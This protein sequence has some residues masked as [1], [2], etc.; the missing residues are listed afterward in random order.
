MPF[1]KDG[2]LIFFEGMSM[3]TLS[4]DKESR[5]HTVDTISD[6]RFS[7]SR[8]DKYST[9]WCNY[10]CANYGTQSLHAGIDILIEKAKQTH[11]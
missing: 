8:T 1:S 5:M 10:K 6:D 11:I 3:H 9:D 7:A 2:N 4:Y